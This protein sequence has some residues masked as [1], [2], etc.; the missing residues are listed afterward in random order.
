MSPGPVKFTP[1]IQTQ[2]TN[3]AEATHVQ[4][5]SRE[6]PT[7]FKAM[8][9]PIGENGSVSFLGSEI[10][11]RMPPGHTLRLLAP[12][13]CRVAFFPMVPKDKLSAREAV[14]SL[15]PEGSPH[16]DYE[17]ARVIRTTRPWWRFW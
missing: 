13:G 4:Y 14:V 9:F 16:K 6:T 5:V 15:E 17:A 2:T 10:F 8:S 3:A 11:V 1:Q 12:E 7:E